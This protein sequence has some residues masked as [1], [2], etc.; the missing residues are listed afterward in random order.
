[1]RLKF[2]EILQTLEVPTRG[3][4]EGRERL[5]K[6]TKGAAYAEIDRVNKI[7][8]KHFGNTNNICTVIDA[9]YAMGQT[10]QERKGVKRNEKRKENKKQEGPN[11]RI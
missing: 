5:M 9:V 7:L 10:I 2:E 6:L 3:N 4:I 8:E 1:M 11:R